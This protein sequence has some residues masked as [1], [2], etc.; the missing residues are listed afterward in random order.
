MES[1][2]SNSHRPVNPIVPAT[3]G[4]KPAAKLEPVVTG[5]VIKRKKSI[6]RR[7]K[8]TFFSGTTDGVLG[9]LL[10]DVLVPAL[11]D[12]TIDMVKQGIEKAVYGDVRSPRSSARGSSL[13]RPH[14]SYDRQSSI[15]RNQPAAR[16]PVTQPSA[17][18]VGEI[19]LESHVQ[20]EAVAEKLYE[21][22]EEYG[23]V[24]V[25]NLNELIGQSSA[26]TDH[27]WGWTDLS[28]LTTKRI[29]EGY[30]MILPEPEDLR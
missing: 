11:Q 6:G 7:I 25:A 23:A 28:H 14:I 20:A 9:Y 3:Q 15:V 1:F 2:P 13:P 8:D 16:R 12:M 29:R 30:L 10:R 17:F 27:K 4:E 26:Y 21:T 22:I 24:T 5:T 19:I 18:Q